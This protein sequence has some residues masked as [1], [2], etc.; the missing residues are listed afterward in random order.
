MNTPPVTRTPS[1]AKDMQK[2]GPGVYLH[3]K[4]IHVSE[5]EICQYLGIRNRQSSSKLIESM[6][7]K[8]LEE[9]Y[10]NTKFEVQEHSLEKGRA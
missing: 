1:W 10:P 3:N 4:S 2:L 5:S 6:V 8:I 7:R 9:K